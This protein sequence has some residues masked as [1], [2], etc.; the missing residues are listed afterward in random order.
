MKRTQ[1]R[2]QIRMLFN[3]PD[4]FASTLLIACCDWFGPEL[5]QWD[6][7]TIRME[8]QDDF[9]KVRG[10]C[11]ERLF[12]AVLLVTTDDFYRRLPDF[13]RFCGVLNGD[14]LSPD[15]DPADL[16]DVT[17]GI[18]EA[19]LLHPPDR[20]NLEP[21]SAEVLGY[22]G[23]L[24]DNAGLVE[25]PDVLRLGVR[26][27]AKKMSDYAADFADDPTMFGAIVDTEKS[28]SDEIDQSIRASLQRL[29]TQLQSLHLVHGDASRL[30][31][32]AEEAAQH[33]PS[34]ILA[35]L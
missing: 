16:D 5:L 34:S 6:S 8:V 26:A 21:F 12:V 31:G 35:D 9:G 2:Q 19:A 30:A 14:T 13:I 3:Q 28:R 32:R 17:W 18:T 10:D 20:D 7:E 15:F 11:L 22:I 23:T 25:P 24:V 33:D 1:Q 29:V 27:D 4:T